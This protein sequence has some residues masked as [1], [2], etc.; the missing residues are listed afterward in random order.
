MLLH[1]GNKY[2]MSIARLEEA[3]SLYKY[4]DI[5]QATIS[6]EYNYI[7]PIV[8]EQYDLKLLFRD[9]L[10]AELHSRVPNEIYALIDGHILDAAARDFER[11]KT[12]YNSDCRLIV[13]RPTRNLIRTFSEIKC[14]Y[15]NIF[16][17]NTP[18][19]VSY[20]LIARNF[21]KPF[22][23]GRVRCGSPGAG[24]SHRALSYFKLYMRIICKKISYD[25]QELTQ[26]E[27]RTVNSGFG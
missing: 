18:P 2:L 10:P 21:N 20:N 3:Q 14:M 15:D 23:E 5:R 12:L 4:N 24:D 9:I 25:T 26:R 13:S 1:S 8:V 19:A 7:L 11:F 6:P 16:R 22:C 27:Q 17:I